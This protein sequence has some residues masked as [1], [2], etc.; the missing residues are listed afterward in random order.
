[1]QEIF[2]HKI[3]KNNNPLGVF[4]AWWLI[5]QNSQLNVKC[6]THLAAVAFGK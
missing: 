5:Y 3:T 2:E 6:A 1:M 4:V